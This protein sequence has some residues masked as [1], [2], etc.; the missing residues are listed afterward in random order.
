MCRVKKKKTLFVTVLDAT[1]GGAQAAEPGTCLLHWQ[2]S[3]VHREP[4]NRAPRG[5]GRATPRGLAGSRVVVG[6][7]QVRQRQATEGRQGGAFLPSCR[8]L[9]QA[10]CTMRE[11]PLET[12]PSRAARSATQNSR[13]ETHSPAV[14]GPAPTASV[15][16]GKSLRGQ[17][18]NRRGGSRAGFPPGPSL[19]TA[20]EQRV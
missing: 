2:S 1:R 3:E 11:T 18:D 7:E 4:Q 8:L 6:A 14:P 17:E 9:V 15:T 19:L 13:S 16:R 5:P 10:K 12:P 20:A